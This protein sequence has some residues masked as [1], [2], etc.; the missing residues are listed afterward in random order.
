MTSSQTIAKWLFERVGLDV[1]LT[2]DLLEERECGRSATWYWRQVSIAVWVGV[3]SAI[4]N[5]KVDALRVAAV[6]FGLE[7]LAILVWKLYGPRVLDLSTEQWMIQS[8]GALLASVLIGWL[9]ADREHPLPSVILFAIC[10][11]VWFLV[12]DDLF[13]IKM[14]VGSVERPMFRPDLVM[15]FVTLFSQDAGLVIGGMLVHP[16]RKPA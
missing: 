1:G 8:W 12:G 16:R 14:L 6:G 13:W 5:R 10:L 4:R 15:F 9:I 7:Y 2:G 11:S 3:W